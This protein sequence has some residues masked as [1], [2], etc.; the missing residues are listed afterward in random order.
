MRK[1]FLK[2]LAIL[3]ILALPLMGSAQNNWPPFK[4][5]LTIIPGDFWYFM[6]APAFNSLY[7]GGTTGSNGFINLN[8]VNIGNT[9]VLTINYVAEVLKQTN[10][11]TGELTNIVVTMG[12]TNIMVVKP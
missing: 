11:I 4:P 3:A 2:F 8:G 6:E 7:V 12:S 9:E 5:G 1:S 10:E